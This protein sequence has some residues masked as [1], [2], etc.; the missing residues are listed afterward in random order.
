MASPKAQKT[1]VPQRHSADSFRGR[2]PERAPS[3]QH[4]PR[5]SIEIVKLW[6]FG[7][8]PDIG[9]RQLRAI[10]EQEPTPTEAPHYIAG[11]GFEDPFQKIQRQMD[12]VPDSTLLVVSQPLIPYIDL[13]ARRSLNSKVGVSTTG[14]PI[15]SQLADP[16]PSLEALAGWLFELTLAPPDTWLR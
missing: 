14:C 6:Y 2:R 1:L 10:W 16:M 7:I 9:V 12:F 11:S 15:T 3:N 8:G 4:A 5:G 13:A